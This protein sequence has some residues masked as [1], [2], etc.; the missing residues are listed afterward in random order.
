MYTACA[1]IAT[2]LDH[3][4]GLLLDDLNSLTFMNF[5]GVIWLLNPLDKGVVIWGAVCWLVS[6]CL[7]QFEGLYW[8]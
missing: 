6:A 7:E 4:V 5:D 3:D 1:A 2:L 8:H